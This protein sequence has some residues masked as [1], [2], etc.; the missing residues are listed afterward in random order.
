M[1]ERFLNL[2]TTLARCLAVDGD[3]MIRV[4]QKRAELVNEVVEGIAI[5]R[6]DDKLSAVLI[7]GNSVGKSVREKRFAFHRDELLL[8]HA[9]H[10]VTGVRR[11]GSVALLALESVAINQ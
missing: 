8:H 7:E 9:A 3:D 6:E 10:E 1:L 2:T 11:V 4:A 5:L